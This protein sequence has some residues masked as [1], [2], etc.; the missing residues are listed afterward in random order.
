[1]AA[2]DSVCVVAKNTF[3]DLLENDDMDAGL[4]GAV[5]RRG[6]S[7]TDTFVEY[8]VAKSDLEKF[9][10]ESTLSTSAN[11]TSDESV[12]DWN[13]DFS[14][15][16]DDVSAHSN[17]IAPPPGC[18]TGAPHGAPAQTIPTVCLA[19][20][21]CVA[22]V[23]VTVTEAPVWQKSSRSARRRRARAL[24]RWYRSIGQNCND[25]IDGELEHDA[26]H[27]EGDSDA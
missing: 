1:M 26:E 9:D 2:A 17:K 15:S 8:G 13:D 18:W 23:P 7:F 27:E 6:R 12:A 14:G 25:Q 3:L 4:S 11:D 10:C 20:P 22:L 24:N 19:A 16:D 21:I 5:M